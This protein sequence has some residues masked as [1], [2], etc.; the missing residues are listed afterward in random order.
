MKFEKCKTCI[1]SYSLNKARTLIYLMMSDLNTQG[2]IWCKQI[3]KTHISRNPEILNYNLYICST[4]TPN[5]CHIRNLCT[6]ATLHHLVLHLMK[7]RNSSYTNHSPRLDYYKRNKFYSLGN[8]L[9][10]SH[11]LKLIHRNMNFSH[12]DTHKFH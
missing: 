10:S 2:D 4:I 12:K 6:K 11:I 3:L 1:L 5:I 9:H 8:C 7:T